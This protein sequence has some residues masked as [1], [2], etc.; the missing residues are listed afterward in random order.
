MNETA[1]WMFFEQ[2]CIKMKNKSKIQFFS[3]LTEIDDRILFFDIC[4]ETTE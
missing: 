2:C 4:F 1:F 3:V